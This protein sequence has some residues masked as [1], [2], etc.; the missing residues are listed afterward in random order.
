[1]IRWHH[2][3]PFD[4]DPSDCLGAVAILGQVGRLEDTCVNLDTVFYGL[5][6][7]LQSLRSETPAEIDLVEE[8]DLLRGERS[9]HG[10]TLLY[11]QQSVE[12]HSMEEFE[13]ALRTSVAE[14]L[15]SLPSEPPDWDTYAELRRFVGRED[16]E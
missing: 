11:G 13:R 15:D 9:D 7:L 5:L 1:M 3:D 8:P 10:V 14:F 6:R 2:D 4:V 16:S 12:L